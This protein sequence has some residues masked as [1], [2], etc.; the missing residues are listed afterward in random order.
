MVGHQTL[1]LLMEVRILHPQCGKLRL[2]ELFCLNKYQYYKEMLFPVFLSIFTKGSTPI[3]E[4]YVVSRL[5]IAL[6][7]LKRLVNNSLQHAR[8][9]EEK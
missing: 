1:N 6:R 9:F 8:S 7:D 5:R 4:N 3:M 2:T